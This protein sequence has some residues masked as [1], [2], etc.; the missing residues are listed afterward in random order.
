MRKRIQG[1][2]Q[3]TQKT[4]SAGRARPRQA[5]LEVEIPASISVGNLARLLEME[6]AGIIKQLMRK[7]IMADI[8]MVLAF[9][10]AVA[11]ADGVGCKARGYTRTGAIS[12]RGRP[13]GGECLPRSPVVTVMGH[14]DHGKTSLLDVIRQSNVTATEAGDITQHIGAYKVVVGEQS[15]TFLDT[16]GHEAFTAMRSRGAQITDIVVLVIAADEGIMPQ[17]EEAINHAR[18]AGVPIIVAINKMDKPGADVERVKQQLANLELVVEEW[19]GDTIYVPISAKQKQ[20]IQDLLENIIV[21]ADILEL[22]AEVDCPA[23]GVIIEAKLDKN[24][25][26]LATVLIQRGVLKPGATVAAGSAY[27]RIKAMFDDKGEVV[28]QAG[29]AEPVEILGLNSVPVAGDSFVVV[30]DEREARSIIDHQED[31]V[32]RV[33]MNLW[34]ISSQIGRGELR[35]FNVVLRTDVQGSI[36]PI[37]GSLERLG[38]EEVAVKVI[39]AAAGNITESDVFLASAS[40]GVII[41]FNSYPASSVRQLAQKEKVNIRCYEVIYTLVEEIEKVLKGMLEPTYME[42]VTGRAEVRE[43]FRTSKKSIAGVYVKE[44]QMRRGSSARVLRGGRVVHESRI[45][46]LK[47]FKEDVA[48]VADGYECGVGLEKF[49]EFSPGD[50]IEA[51]HQEQSE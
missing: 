30:V 26:T 1:N 3:F 32:H 20:G 47:R 8:N 25:G 42:V 35:S 41:G 4:K 27:G 14:V 16:P 40:E 44:G 51:Y 22:K 18:A 37:K 17:T 11:I 29:P 36:E 49:T 19:G 13:G 38:T 50:V 46:S 7:N 6:P 45:S 23:E 39:Q 28:K 15:I 5:V 10:D 34:D 43:I 48:E 24:K 2:R 21:V 31:I 9:D 33:P 12:S